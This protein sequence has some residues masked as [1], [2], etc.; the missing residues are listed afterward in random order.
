MTRLSRRRLGVLLLATTAGGCGFQLRRAPDLPFR[1]V[2]L[3]G[4]NEGHGTA[5]ELRRAMPA[6]VAVVDDPRQAEVVLEALADER[7]R[8]VSATTAAAQVRE[9]VLVSRVVYRLSTRAGQPLLGPTEIA[10]SRPMSYSETAALPKAQ[11]E[12]G[13]WQAM[14]A[15]IALQVLRR[16]AATPKA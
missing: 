9:V 3:V 7:R 13:L 12:Q 1:S 16:L 10:L 4:F 5:R 15:D 8:T 11:E 2:T 6:G 14:E